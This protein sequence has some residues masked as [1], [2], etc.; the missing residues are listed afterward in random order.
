MCKE[1]H[2]IVRGACV[3]AGRGARV[4][5]SSVSQGAAGLPGAESA[6]GAEVHSGVSTQCMYWRVGNRT[7]GPGASRR[8]KLLLRSPPP[9]LYGLLRTC[10]SMAHPNKPVRKGSSSPEVTRLGTGT[11][12]PDSQNDVSGLIC[13]T[14]RWCFDVRGLLLRDP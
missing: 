10:T 8:R 2:A 6:W 9:A 1:G 14:E 4:S 13:Y 3:F 7:R 11:Q 5:P 12:F